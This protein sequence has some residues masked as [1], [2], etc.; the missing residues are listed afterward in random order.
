VRNLSASLTAIGG[1]TGLEDVSAV[2]SPPLLVKS[3]GHEH[4][5]ARGYR[6]SALPLLAWRPCEFASTS[7]GSSLS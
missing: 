3:N 5:E 6:A 7:N 2:Q 1:Y 4:F